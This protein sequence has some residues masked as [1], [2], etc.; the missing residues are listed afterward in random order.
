MKYFLFFIISFTLIYFFTKK[1]YNLSL[2]FSLLLFLLITIYRYNKKVFYYT[3]I[4]IAILY[5]LFD[6][7][8]NLDLLNFIML[9]Y[10]FISI[11]ELLVHKYFMH[12]DKGKFISKYF[13][14]TYTSHINH[15]ITVEP[16]MTLRTKDSSGLFMQ[17][18]EYGFMSLG[19]FIITI[20]SKTISNYRISLFN[21]GII[22]LINAY[23]WSYLWN[24]IHNKM[25]YH[26]SDFT[27]KDGPYDNNLVNMDFI[28]NMLLD[29]H[30]KHHMLKGDNQCNYNVI[31]LGAD[32]W[33][34][35]HN[36]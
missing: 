34:N 1:N 11:L 23:L 8:K 29:N 5:T 32:E 17:W 6:C 14:D 15:H 21:C 35:T 2:F 10:I 27:I 4:S 19:I 16:D 20:L 30:T 36:K 18:S 31:L 12:S 25:H 22:A 26:N 9:I 33:F 13:A 28:K 24:K 3:L 7:E